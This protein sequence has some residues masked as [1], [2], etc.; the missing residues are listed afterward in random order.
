MKSKI[1]KSSILGLVL[2]LW[3]ISTFAQIKEP[4][5][6]KW[7]FEAPTA[8]D[9]FT[10]GIVTFKKDS[11][12]TAF[13]DLNY[14]IQSN[15]IKVKS[16]SIIYEVFVDDEPVIF[17]LKMNKKPKATGNALWSGGETQI[18]LTKKEE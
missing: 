11:V 1:C 14:T 15:W 4:Y 17:S 16:D 5:I 18:F 3:S 2:I 8:P 13:P 10:N 9:G 7:R 12:V 6:G